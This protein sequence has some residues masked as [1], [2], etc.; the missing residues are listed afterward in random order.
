MKQIWSKNDNVQLL[1]CLD[2]L[3]PCLCI[4]QSIWRNRAR[5]VRTAT[6]VTRGAGIGL[7]S[8]SRR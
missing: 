5:D 8:S 7:V 3:L 2:E 6:T 1:G 4:A